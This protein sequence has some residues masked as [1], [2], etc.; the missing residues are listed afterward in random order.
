MIAASEN[1][2]SIIHMLTDALLSQTL[3]N[4]GSAK[5]TL[6]SGC[7]KKAL[8]SKDGTL[9]TCVGG[10]PLATAI[11]NTSGHYTSGVHM[12]TCA[13]IYVCK[14]CVQTFSYGN[15]DSL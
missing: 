9:K 11:A 12:H 8:R 2:N 7:L 6:W 14:T 5:T 3:T 1:F 10:F 13:N 4:S 15:Y